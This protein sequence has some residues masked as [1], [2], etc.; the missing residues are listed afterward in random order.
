VSVQ[1]EVRAPL[2]IVL[3]EPEIAANAGSIGRTCV[4]LGA[5][6]WLVR[7]LGFH[8][9]D[10]HRRRA[11]LDYWDRLQVRVVDSL[12]EALA[13]CASGRAWYFSARAR[14]SYLD[15]EYRAGDALIFG[16]ESRGLPDAR[17]GTAGEHALRIPI[18][19]EARCLNLAVAAAVA[20]FEAARQLEQA[21]RRIQRE[22]SAPVDLPK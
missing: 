9:G 18:A 7:P 12:D 2:H 3:V 4:A 19:P 5:A 14:R 11:G 17:I 13:A 22:N 8:L 16:P 1:S 10:R 21:G 6:L 20:G 15:A